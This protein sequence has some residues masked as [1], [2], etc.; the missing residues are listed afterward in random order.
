M[1]TFETQ[2][3]NSAFELNDSSGNS[4]MNY[5]P[6]KSYSSVIVY[7]LKQLKAKINIQ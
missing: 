5:T 4:I 3:A 6:I 7:T 2:A 1:A